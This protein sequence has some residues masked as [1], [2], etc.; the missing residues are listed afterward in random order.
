MWIFNVAPSL[1]YRTAV[2]Y[3]SKN[4][5]VLFE[6]KV[7]SSV[8]PRS[9]SIKVVSIARASCCLVFVFGSHRWA[10]SKWSLAMWPSII[11]SRRRCLQSVSLLNTWLTSFE[12]KKITSSGK[13]QRNLQV[14]M[15]LVFYSIKVILLQ[16]ILKNMVSKLDELDFWTCLFVC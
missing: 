2:V 15:K 11:I 3:K 14:D 5:S 6:V 16:S 1:Y 10:E 7:C 9:S 12:M 13:Q 8:S 4:N